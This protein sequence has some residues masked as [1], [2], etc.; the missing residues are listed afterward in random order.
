[1]LTILTWFSHRLS[2]ITNSDEIIVLHKGK[3]VEKGTHAELIMMGGSYHAMWQKQTTTE[4]KEREKEE[5]ES[6]ETASQ[7]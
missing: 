5:G 4:K 7:G 3:V 1:M 6:L 2:T